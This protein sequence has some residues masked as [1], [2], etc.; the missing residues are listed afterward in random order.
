MP[1]VDPIP[2]GYPNV[3]PYLIVDDATR[4][5]AFYAR[6]FGAVET[7]RL[8]GPGAVMMHAEMRIGSGVIMLSNES[9]EW[10]AYSPMRFGGSPVTICLYVADVDAVF[11]QAIAAG[12]IAKRPLTDQFYGDRTACLVDPFGHEWHLASRRENLT[13]E[14]LR[15]RLATWIEER[16]HTRQKI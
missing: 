3:L 13:Q 7:L 15:S 4:A 9:E 11:A 14:E 2:A 10:K 6:A 12:G 8:D 16:S 5:L 1:T